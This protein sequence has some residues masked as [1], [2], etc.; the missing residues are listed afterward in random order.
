[1]NEGAAVKKASAH[2]A[3]SSFNEPLPGLR[4]GRASGR[5]RQR[6][7]ALIQHIQAL[8]KQ[9]IAASRIA[10]LSQQARQFGAGLRITFNLETTFKVVTRFTPQTVLQTQ[11]T[12]RQ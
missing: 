8:L 5:Q 7:Q 11:T 12:Q 6:Q 3:R 2:R 9:L 10:Q 1:M 4:T